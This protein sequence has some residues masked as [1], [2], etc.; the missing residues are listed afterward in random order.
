M[1]RTL[2]QAIERVARNINVE[3]LSA[4]AVLELLTLGLVQFDQMSLE[5]LDEIAGGGDSSSA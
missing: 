2:R 3:A 1:T 4:D 5:Q